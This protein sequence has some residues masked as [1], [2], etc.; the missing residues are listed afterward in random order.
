[1]LAQFEAMKLA[2]DRVGFD[3][4]YRTVREIEAWSSE[5]F[6]N[7]SFDFEHLSGA[8]IGCWLSHLS[9]W[10]R[11]R[12]CRSLRAATVIED[13]VVLSRAFPDAVA[14]LAR[15][16]VY[17]IVYLGTSSRNIS[18]RRRVRVGDCWL[19]EP[20]GTVLNTWAYVVS[21]EFVDRFF[22]TPYLRLRV[23]ID[24]F[25]GGNATQAGPRVAVLQPPVV[26]EDAVLGSVSQIEPYTFRVDRW[27]LVERA[28]RSLLESRVGS[29]YYTL[30]RWL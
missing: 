2:F 10:D 4:R 17:D 29:L 11:L 1:M 25:L 19:H 9:A 23:P 24:H 26:T 30:Y 28:R 20:V 13:D 16:V 14:A 21:T 7:V 8:E 15:N 22:A 3:G 6:G 12:N 5:R 18:A 27:K